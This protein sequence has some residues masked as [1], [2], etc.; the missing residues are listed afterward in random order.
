MKVRIHRIEVPLPPPIGFV[1]AYLVLHDPVTLI[2]A[3]LLG[4]GNAE[5]LKA[6]LKQYG[7]ETNDVRRI[8]LT[9]GHQDHY[10]LAPEVFMHKD[11]KVFIHEA[12][13]PKID[14]TY[15][16]KFLK[17]M[18]KLTEFYDL[19]GVPRDIIMDMMAGLENGLGKAGGALSFH[20]TGQ[21][22]QSRKFH[23]RIIGVGRDSPRTGPG[24]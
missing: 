11:L 23:Y 24:S 4:H 15:K 19:A 10:S 5:R 16:E 17:N 6:G 12:D 14:G 21:N 1:N 8:A 22:G 9:H 18:A 20:A 7:I 2:D 3:G 13:F